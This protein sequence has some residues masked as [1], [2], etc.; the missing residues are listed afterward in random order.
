MKTGNP[1]Q[2]HAY[3]ALHTMDIQ[4]FLDYI[5]RWYTIDHRVYQYNKDRLNHKF[6]TYFHNVGVMLPQS[7]FDTF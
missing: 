3:P 7:Q 6:I 4:P 5:F 2:I 1:Q